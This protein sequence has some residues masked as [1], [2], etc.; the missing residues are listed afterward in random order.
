MAAIED[1]VERFGFDRRVADD[2]QELLMAP[3]V[4]FMRGDVEIAGD[5][6][7]ALEDGLVEPGGEF[8]EEPQLVLELGVDLGVGLVAA[9]R[10]IEIVQRQRAMAEIGQRRDVARFGDIEENPAGNVG[11]R[12]FRDVATP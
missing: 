11:Q 8:A 1:G 2:L 7:A 6:M 9:G 4:V 3:D 5:Q 10:N 12:E